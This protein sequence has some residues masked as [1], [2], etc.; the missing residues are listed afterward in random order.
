VAN[1][2]V[3]NQDAV[4][5]GREVLSLFGSFWISLHRNK[6][7]FQAYG[8]GLS[9]LLAQRMMDLVY[10]IQTLSRFS[11]PVY[12]AMTWRRVAFTEQ[13]LQRSFAGALKYGDGLVYGIAAEDVAVYL[14]G[15]RSPKEPAKLDVD[16]LVSIGALSTSPV[17]ASA[18]LA[19]GVDFWVA[20]GSL[21][22]RNNPFNDPRMPVVDI[23]DDSGAVVDR[24]LALWGYHCEYDVR[25][26]ANRYGA[27]VGLSAASSDGFKR[28]VNAAIDS[29]CDGPSLG[30]FRELLYAWAGV[31]GSRS[32]GERVLDI[33]RLA[34][35]TVVVTDQQAYCFNSAATIL[36]EVGDVLEKGQAIC[37]A[38]QLLRTPREL[39]QL[40][41]L[42]VD[43]RL[44][45]VAS[46]ITFPNA[47][48]PISV[49]T[50][51]GRMKISCQLLGHPAVI[52]KFWADVHDRGVG[53]TTLANTLDLRESPSGDPAIT[54]IPQ[55]L[56][57][58][59]LLVSEM[60]G[61][62][63][64]VRVN[65]TAFANSAPLPLGDII[66]NIIPARMACL[67]LVETL[68]KT[69]YI[70][71]SDDGTE[72]Q[73]G[74]VDSVDDWIFTEA[75]TNDLVYGSLVGS[76]PGL[77]DDVVAWYLNNPCGST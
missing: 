58:L 45:D 31:E 20:D 40:S 5:R 33:A 54:D 14:Y 26:I 66:A 67:M 49:S 19:A 4:Q 28:L 30:A 69:E 36:V 1:Y 27:L 55:T 60:G 17:G 38:V 37:D 57:P 59:D 64:V 23:I 52:R 13:G 8:R 12:R 74:A 7:L 76:D 32:D 22:F 15:N 46:P 34:T 18:I 51:K 3:D 62:L 61:S 24:G 68:N 48:L 35:G 6:D 47:D 21:V 43:S 41:G 53:G 9:E 10:S 11:V 42:C 44:V 2:P 72:T 56:N 63:L 70:D 16:N 75:G 39:R 50:A 77:D 65:L 29:L 73:A 25:D 71:L